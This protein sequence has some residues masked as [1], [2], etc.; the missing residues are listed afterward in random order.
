M[1]SKMLIMASHGVGRTALQVTIFAT[2]LTGGVTL[3]SSS[4]F[5]SLT[6]QSYNTSA[7]AVTVGTLQLTQ[8]DAGS[9]FTTAISGM[10]PGDTVNRFVTYTNGGTLAATGLALSISDSVT[11]QLTG[12]ASVGLN[13]TINQC[14][15]AW[16]TA[17]GVCSGTTTALGA[18]ATT[19]FSLKTTPLALPVTSQAAGAV[20]YIKFSIALPA[21]SEVTTNGTLPGGTIQGQTAAITWTLNE[22][23]R[24][25]TTT[26][27]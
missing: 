3:A 23:Q 20:S 26:N 22:T 6:A 14:S 19:L 15:V 21:G 11:S 24:T 8:A 9:G 1:I 27:S 17:T 16:T 4:V 12:S 13:V 25:A 2:A 5:A 7:T 10:A 18:P